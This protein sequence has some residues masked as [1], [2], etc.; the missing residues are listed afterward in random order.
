MWRR[1]FIIIVIAI[2]SISANAL[3][4]SVKQS[5]QGVSITSPVQGDVLSGVVNIIG[6]SEISG[7]AH[8][9]LAF[10]NAVGSM[11]TWFPISKSNNSC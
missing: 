2:L 4:E 10:S 7:F 11:A 3:P 1:N 8:S 6:T 5:D 9:E